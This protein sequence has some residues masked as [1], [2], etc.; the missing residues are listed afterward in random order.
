MTGSVGSLVLLVAVLL[1]PVILLFAFAGCGAFGTEPTPEGPSGP[2]STNT[3]P[4]NG[5]P[6]SPAL[7][8]DPYRSEIAKEPG[9]VAY[10]R[11]AETAGNVAQ[12]IGR[13]QRAGVYASGVMLGQVG[14]LAAKQP[15]DT[16]V[17]FD[18][19]QGM[20]EIKVGAEAGVIPPVPDP[21][22]PPLNFSLEAWVNLAPDTA[23]GDGTP[24]VVFDSLQT[25]DDGTV[26]GFTLLVQR[27]PADA[28]TIA[29]LVGNG[30]TGTTLPD[31][32]DEVTIDLPVGALVG[33]WAHVV[34]VRDGST[35]ASGRTLT[36]YLNYLDPATGRP[37]RSVKT[38]PDAT[39]LPNDAQPLRIGAGQAPGG[40]PANFL[41]GR[42]DEVA[43][44][45]N[46]LPPGRVEAHFAMSMP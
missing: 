10:W 30:L 28:P 45:E 15:G 46:V 2:G 44:Y 17:L 22:L 4:K 29:G 25:R 5:P 43:L 13:F 9:L 8:G 26:R 27:E 35:G 41:T 1:V 33:S 16:A 20:V 21:L 36:L 23:G 31:V 32:T 40:G 7:P 39:Y 18:G 37:V 19:V 24:D 34:L 38:T 3:P 14:A 12:D 42:I 11:L 6:P